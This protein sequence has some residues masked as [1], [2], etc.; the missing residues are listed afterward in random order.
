MTDTI[1]AS[2]APAYKDDDLVYVDPD[3][4][5][6]VGLVEFTVTGKPKSLARPM[7]VF[8]KD[9]EIQPPAE[10]DAAAKK[11]VAGKPVRRSAP[12]RIRYY[13]WGTYRSMRRIYKLE[14]KQ[15]REESPYTLN[16]VIEKALNQP[17]WD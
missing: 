5:T 11:P 17:F 10:E 3:T 12:M 2:E 8:T 16:D 15:P 9:K 13:P 7:T 14:G 6:V 1:P 4:R